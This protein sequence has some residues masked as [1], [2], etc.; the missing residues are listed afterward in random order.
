MLMPSLQFKQHFHHAAYAHIIS[1]VQ[2]G[3]RAG[4]FFAGILLAGTLLASIVAKP[5]LCFDHARSRLYVHDSCYWCAI[6]AKGI[7]NSGPHRLR[8]TSA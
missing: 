5:P 1:C 4:I 7:H 3:N 8:A 6:L 2:S